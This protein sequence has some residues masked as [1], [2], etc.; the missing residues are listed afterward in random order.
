MT[1]KLKI[2]RSSTTALPTTADFGEIVLTSVAG[3]NRLFIGDSTNTVVEIAGDN[4]MNVV[5]TATAGDIATLDTTGQVVDSTYSIETTLSGSATKIPSSLAIQNAILAAQEGIDAKQSALA[6]TTAPLPAC[7]VT[8]SGVGKTLTANFSGVLVVDG[9]NVWTDVTVDGGS[10]NP[11]A[12]T[13]RAS[14]VLVKN[15]VNG[16]DNGI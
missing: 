8:G 9:V 1:Q 10:A 2:K 11:F 16:A 4:K 6:A 5:G 12:S 15:Q 13:T 3:K 14:R 7:T